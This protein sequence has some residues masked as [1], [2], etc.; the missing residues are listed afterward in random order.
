MGVKMLS[1]IGN[2]EYITIIVDG[3]IILPSVSDEELKS[4]QYSKSLTQAIFFHKWA[5]YFK[6]FFPSNLH[7]RS[8]YSILEKFNFYIRDYVCFLLNID[9]PTVFSTINSYFQ[10]NVNQNSRFFQIPEIN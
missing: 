7:L 8:L 4:Q 5:I 10:S 1:L 6:K 3:L 9:F 2:L